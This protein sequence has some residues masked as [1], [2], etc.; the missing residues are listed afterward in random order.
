MLTLKCTELECSAAARAVKLCDTAQRRLTCSSDGEQGHAY[1]RVLAEGSNGCMAVPHVR[2]PLNAHIPAQ[3]ACRHQLL[4]RQ[5]LGLESA[6]PRESSCELCACSCACRME[7]AAGAGHTWRPSSLV[8]RPPE[9]LPA[10]SSPFCVHRVCSRHLLGISSAH[11]L[12][13][14]LLF[15]K[16]GGAEPRQAG[17]CSSLPAALQHTCGEQTAAAWAQ[18]EH[19]HLH[20]RCRSAAGWLPPESHRQAHWP[21]TPPP[22]AAL[23]C[24]TCI[25]GHY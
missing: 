8:S 20:L 10:C 11:A 12:L 25:T 19:L 2:G 1:G 4:V 23:L 9:R 14:C 17:Q 15:C 22:S 18:Q 7:R 21:A 5:A 6:N 13:Q 16:L 24:R 3:H